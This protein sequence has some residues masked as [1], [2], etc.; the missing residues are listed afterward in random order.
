MCLRLLRAMLT[1]PIIHVAVARRTT[2]PATSSRAAGD[3]M[4][5]R[6]VGVD[7]ASTRGRAVAAARVANVRPCC[8]CRRYDRR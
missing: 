7:T 8:L 2:R 6:V 5:A 3:A 4:C 1:L